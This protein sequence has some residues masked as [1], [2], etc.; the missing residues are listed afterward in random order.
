MKPSPRKVSKLLR[1]RHQDGKALL[2]TVSGIAS[3]SISMIDWFARNT[4]VD[5][6]T[7]KSIEIHPNPGNREP[8]I[9]SQNW[10]P[11]ATPLVYAIPASIQ[12]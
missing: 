8:V 3:T 2:A 11:T 12:P 6:I 1:R 7:T 10:V 5:I 4:K 9:T